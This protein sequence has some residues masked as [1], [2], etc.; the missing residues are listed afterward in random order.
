MMTPDQHRRRIKHFHQPGDLHELTFSCCRR[1]PRLTNDA[2]RGLLARAVTVADRQRGGVFCFW[3]KGPGYDRNSSSEAAV[4]ASID[5]IHA[6]PVVRGLVK[7]AIDWRKHHLRW[8]RV[9]AGTGTLGNRD[10]TLN[11]FDGR[12]RARHG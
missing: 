12:V 10:H 7:R 4:L 8:L 1:L 2:W 5:D 6:N 11:V 3:Q 9:T